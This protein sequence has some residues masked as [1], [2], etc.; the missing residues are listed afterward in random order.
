MRSWQPSSS[1]LVAVP[2]TD[3]AAGHDHQEVL[4]GLLDDWVNYV[5]RHGVID[6]PYEALKLE[7]PPH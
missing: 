4:Q 2:A 3:A 5:D 1:A 6:A 7:H